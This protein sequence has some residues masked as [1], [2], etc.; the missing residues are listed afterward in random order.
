MALFGGTFDPPHLGHLIIAEAAREALHLDRI[1]FLIAADPPHKRDI[2]RSKFEDRCAMVE[3][4]IQGSPH[5]AMNL[6]EGLRPGPSFTV[7]TLQLRR[8]EASDQQLWFLM[9]ADSL[10]DL[11]TWKAPS[12]I[13]ELA[14]LAV[15]ARPGTAIDTCGLETRLPGVGMSTDIVATTLIDISSRDLRD[16]VRSGRSIAFRSPRQVVELIRD[17]RL[18]LGDSSPT[19]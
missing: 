19:S 11:P 1:E 2:A 3:L 8:T 5:F 13:I 6:S 12:T 18:Y 9:G 15:A 14:R 17:R 7:D 10:V 4:A 16:R